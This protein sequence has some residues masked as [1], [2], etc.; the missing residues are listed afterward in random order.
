MI[1]EDYTNFGG[2]H[3]DTA[4]FQNAL[5]YQGVVAPHTGA[6]FSEAMLY[7]INGG[8]GAA[9]FN[10]VYEDFGP[11]LF[12][13]TGAR[14]KTRSADLMKGLCQRLGLE[15]TDQT[16]G[17][18][19]VAVKN[20]LQGLGQGRAVI[21]YLSLGH[22]PYYALEDIGSGYEH[23]VVVYGHPRDPEEDSEVNV[24]DLPGVPLVLRAA[25]LTGARGFVSAIKNRSLSIGSPPGSV[26]MRA[27][28]A[29]VRAGIRACY[30]PMIDPP[31]PKSNFGLNALEKWAHLAADPRD[32]KGWPSV[33]P[34]GASLYGAQK[35]VYYA[36]E[37]LGTG[38]GA[39]RQLYADFLL[40][41]AEVLG[42]ASL[43]AIAGQ[44]RKAA[45]SWRALAE[46]ALPDAVPLFQ[47]TKVLARR[48]YQLALEKGTAGLAEIQKIK[49]QA[50][51]VT[52]EVEASY[53]LDEA[54]SGALY[55]SLREHIQK[56]HRLERQAATSLQRL[57]P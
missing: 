45:E 19:R 27:L 7:G 33:F 30:G 46:A 21:V 44:Y 10:I 15:M 1:L 47:E 25:E 23:A 57:V 28:E 8:I 4:A 5:A 16:T 54:Q 38:G 11:T 32:K 6:A 40:E 48:K 31:T 18:P 22:L 42:E 41:A 24:A 17:S 9:Y 12:V 29:A 26:D 55:E 50:R 37:I 53:P 39:G 3:T 14:Y 56:V 34:P 49:E 51:A 52:A 36:V 13:G 35:T 2:T 20:V 43:R